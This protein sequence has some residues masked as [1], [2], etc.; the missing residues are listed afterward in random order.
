MDELTLV[1]VEFLDEVF[2][3]FFQICQAWLVPVVGR[4]HD[5]GVGV[6]CSGVADHIPRFLQLLHRLPCQPNEDI[7]F[8]A[9]AKTILQSLDL[10]EKQG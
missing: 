3:T 9:A 2:R 10:P 7:Y 8:L 5:L 4:D 1:S 6:R